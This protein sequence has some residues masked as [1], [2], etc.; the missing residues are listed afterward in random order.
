LNEFHLALWPC[1]A[2]TMPGISNGFM[3]LVSSYGMNIFTLPLSIAFPAPTHDFKPMVIELWL[4]KRL[5]EH[6]GRLIICVDGM[7]SDF[8]SLDVV[9]EVGELD[10]DVLGLR[11]HLGDFGNFE[12]TAVILKNLA[13]DGWQCEDHFVSLTL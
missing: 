10:I 5:C 8:A 1:V 2:G 3:E 9:A 4:V 13:V 11:L 6:V 7:E 12:C